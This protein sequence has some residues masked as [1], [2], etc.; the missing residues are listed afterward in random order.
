MGVIDRTQ[1]TI[2][3]DLDGTIRTANKNFLDVLGYKLDEVVGRH[4][5]MFVDKAYT[6]TA[7]YEEFW[8]ALRAGRSFTSPYPR[9]HKDGSVVWISA[10]YAP[11]LDASGKAVSVIKIATDIS[12]RQKGITDIA[13][14]LVQ[15][16]KGNLAHVIPPCGAEDIQVLVDSFNQ[17]V[18]SLND[19]VSAVKAVAGTVQRTAGEIG[20]SSFDLARRTEQQ[21]ATLEETAA[22]IEELTATV[23]ASADSAQEMEKTAGSAQST[24]RTGG[25]VVKDAVGAMSEIER[26]SDRISHVIKIIDDIAFQT[27][28][29]AL[30]AGVEA[31]RAGESGRGFAVVASEVRTLAVR[32]AD[33]ASEIKTLIN[34]SSA[35]VSNGVNLVT[36]AGEELERIIAAVSEIHSH[37][38]EIAHGAAEQAI[39]LN[40]I[41]T[42]VSQLDSMTQQ[43]AAMVEESTAAGQV[44]EQDATELSNHVSAFRTRD[45]GRPASQRQQPDRRAPLKR[46]S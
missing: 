24:A 8:Q 7:E 37:V 46:A 4:H 1:A 10:T 15:L 6:Q 2:Q 13:D 30:N 38:S 16:S 25:N 39:T 41:N 18:S 19:V 9:L 33:S 45:T 44:L 26:S 22:A 34:D 20:Q 27:N 29:L 42:A 43:N 35:H 3:F 28:L 23:K 14:G 5:S 12:A 36:R 17:T 32:S 11:V 21:A 40:E 31:A